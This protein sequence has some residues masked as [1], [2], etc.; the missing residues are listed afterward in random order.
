MSRHFQLDMGY[1]NMWSLLDEVPTDELDSEVERL[2]KAGQENAK[3]LSAANERSRTIQRKIHV[4]NEVSRTRKR[5]ELRKTVEQ[6]DEHT[7][8]M[9]LLSEDIIRQAVDNYFDD[10]R[11]LASE[12]KWKLPNDDL[13]DGQR[14]KLEQLLEELPM[15]IIKKLV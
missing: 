7:K 11:W 10:Y 5:A 15:L 3:T 8:L 14:E 6:T 13:S 4:L 2:G 1:E 9:S 12:L